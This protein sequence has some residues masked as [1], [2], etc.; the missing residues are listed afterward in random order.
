MVRYHYDFLPNLSQLVL[1]SVSAA[2]SVK[3]DH[4][5]MDRLSWLEG[6]LAVLDPM[7]PEI[8]E[9]CQRIMGVVVQRLE[10]LYMSVSVADHNNPIL[11]KIPAIARRAK[12]LSQASARQA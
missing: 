4:K 10:Q 11:R 8:H 1:L 5:V 7:D 3:F 6:V 2:V 9:I 12:E